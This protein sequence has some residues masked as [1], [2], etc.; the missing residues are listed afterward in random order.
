MLLFDAA[1]SVIRTQGL[2]RKRTRLNGN[3]AFVGS[4]IDWLYSLARSFAVC[5]TIA[6]IYK[7]YFWFTSNNRGWD[8]SMQLARREAHDSQAHPRAWAQFNSI[9]THYLSARWCVSVCV[10][11]YEIKFYFLPLVHPHQMLESLQVIPLKYSISTR[12]KN[13]DNFKGKWY[14]VTPFPLLLNFPF[15]YFCCCW[16]KSSFSFSRKTRGQLNVRIWLPIPV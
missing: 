15:Q 13:E 16:Q 8:M 1:C 3:L 7:P 10:F 14:F 4:I 9:R 6:D 5:S 11:E 12:T 2:E